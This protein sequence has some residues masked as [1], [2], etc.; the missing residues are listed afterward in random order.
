MIK[1]QGGY[2]RV[3]LF[4]GLFFYR[5]NNLYNLHYSSNKKYHRIFHHIFIYKYVSKCSCRFLYDQDNI[6][7]KE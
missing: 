3:R 1:I 6:L 2:G 4:D 5:I 7:Y